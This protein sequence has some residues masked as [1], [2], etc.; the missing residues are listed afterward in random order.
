MFF[1]K[2]H[3]FVIKVLRPTVLLIQFKYFISPSRL[4]H[5]LDLN[6]GLA[7]SPDDRTG[8]PRCQKDSM[9]P[10]CT[11]TGKFVCQRR[12]ILFIPWK[13]RRG[14]LP[15]FHRVSRIKGMIYNSCQRYSSSQSLLNV[16]CKCLRNW[17][18]R[19]GTYDVYT[20]NPLVKLS[21]PPLRKEKSLVCP[22]EHVKCLGRRSGRA[23]N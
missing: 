13:L 6:E 11:S 3:I 10:V 22:R 21:F 16:S 7:R 1:G 8:V 18:P 14:D 2:F 20:P 9:Y 23:W 19:T 4:L 5:T 17:S 12:H 15:F